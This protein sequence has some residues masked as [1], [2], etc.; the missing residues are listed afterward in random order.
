[1]LLMHVFSGLLRIREEKRKRLTIN[2]STRVHSVR[3]L[4]FILSSSSFCVAGHPANGLI[5]WI[6]CSAEEMS[7][8]LAAV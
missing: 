6:K 8:S 2:H 4:L 1:M 3:L 7:G 5:S